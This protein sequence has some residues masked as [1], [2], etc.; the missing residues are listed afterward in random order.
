MQKSSMRRRLFYIDVVVF[1]AVRDK[2]WRL[3]NATG[4]FVEL[5]MDSI[6]AL[7]SGDWK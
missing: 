7:T 1:V 2:V 3:L 5:V 4:F 6:L